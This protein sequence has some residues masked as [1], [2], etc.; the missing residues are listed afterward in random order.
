MTMPDNF[1][2]YDLEEARLAREEAKRPHCDMCGGA[3]WEDYGYRIDDMLICESCI[4]N[5]K[6]YIEEV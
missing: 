2:L 1:T 6:E 4:E 3:I 5:A